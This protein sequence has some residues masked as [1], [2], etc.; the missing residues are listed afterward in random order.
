MREKGSGGPE[1]VKEMFD[2]EGMSDDELSKK[3]QEI[4]GHDP[5]M[6]PPSL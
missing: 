2:I 4:T 6:Y 5:E 1:A 3:Y